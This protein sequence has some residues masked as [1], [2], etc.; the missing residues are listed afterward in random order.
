MIILDTNI[1]SGA[2]RRQPEERIIRWLDAQA[3][4]TLYICTMSLAEIFSGIAQMPQGRRREKLREDTLHLLME[5]FDGERILT[6]D[7]AAAAAYA[8]MQAKAKA[9]GTPIGVADG[10][11]AATAISRGFAVASGD[12]QPFKAAGLEVINPWE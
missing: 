7:E 8:T 10:I 6:F 12:V 11:I 2:C 9:Q 1:I 3:P 5:L 4:D